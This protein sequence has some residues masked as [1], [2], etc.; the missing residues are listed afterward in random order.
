MNQLLRAT[1]RHLLVGIQN[2]VSVKRPNRV[3]PLLTDLIF[4]ALA[5]YSVLS[6][7]RW[8]V[9]FQQRQTLFFSISQ[10]FI[11]IYQL[12]AL[13]LLLVRRDAV[14]FSAKIADYVYAL[15]ALC[16][17][18]FFQP[19]SGFGASI[20]ADSL[21]LVGAVVVIGAFLSLNRSFGI[22]PENRGIRT[23]GMYR[24]VRHPM[25]SGYILVETSIVLNNLSVLNF[26]ILTMSAFF[27]ALRLQAEEQLLKE[28]PAYQAYAQK[29]QWKLVPFVF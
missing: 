13:S 28:D 4:V 5:F 12:M 24:I 1:K 3:L 8:L 6:Y 29:T 17:P 10:A 11:L 25:Y 26:F 15:V 21:E 7:A 20:G 18:M 2:E 14:V 19:V 27:L 23:T 9:V 22:A 16:S